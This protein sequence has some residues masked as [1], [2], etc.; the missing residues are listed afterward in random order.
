MGEPPASRPPTWAFVAAFAA[1]YLGYGLNYLAIK[2]GVKTLP[3]FLFSGSHVTIAGL[4]V[5][6]WLALGREL[7]WLNWRNLGWAAVGGLTVFVGGT[8][9]IT[10]AETTV[11]SGE[12]SVLR[13]T[14]PVWVA[15]L[16]WVRPNGERLRGLAWIGLILA[17]A[18]VLVMVVP[19]L[20]ASQHLANDLGPLLALA[21]AVAWA[22]GALV[23]RHHRPCASNAVATAYQMTIGGL[24]MVALGLVLGEG[25]KL[26]SADLTK[27]AV[28]AFLFL[29]LV[30]S[31]L[32]FSSLN[33]LLKHVSATLATTKF[34]V[35]PAIAILAGWLVLGEQ[36]T[37]GMIMGMA[38]ILGGV[39]LAMW[40]H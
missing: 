11:N 13:S 19:Q 24:G 36:L 2:E 33:W 18:G 26:R 7:V 5:F 17:V 9:L 16:E 1:V 10:L 35:S 8:G 39:A 29:L 30:H 38:M 3:P 6:G 34:Y 22:V 4:L 12:A 27:D 20:K 15:L 31:L 40:Q 14:T 25:A 21:S 23:L 32:G 37:V 28:F